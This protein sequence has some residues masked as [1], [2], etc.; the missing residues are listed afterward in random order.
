MRCLSLKEIVAFKSISNIIT[1]FILSCGFG[2]PYG[3]WGF[4]HDIQYNLFRMIRSIGG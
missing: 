2:R 3:L 1:E 4:A